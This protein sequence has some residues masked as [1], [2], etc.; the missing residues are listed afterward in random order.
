[1]NLINELSR[2]PNYEKYTEVKNQF[3]LFTLQNKLR[4]YRAIEIYENI[5]KANIENIR[6]AVLIRQKI[7]PNLTT[8]TNAEI[9]HALIKIKEIAR[10][11]TQYEKFFFEKT[12]N[13]NKLITEIST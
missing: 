6:I 8:V 3:L 4:R 10:T 5:E 13:S 12:E 1:L 2:R 11:Q 9:K 7:S